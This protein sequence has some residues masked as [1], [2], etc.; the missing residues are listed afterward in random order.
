MR[1]H[2]IIFSILF[3]ITSCKKEENPG[4]TAETN[5][6]IDLQVNAQGSLYSLVIL[7]DYVRTQPYTDG[8]KDC[9]VRNTD[10]SGI[11]V[12][13][14]V[15]FSSHGACFATDPNHTSGTFIA[16]YTTVETDTVFIDLNGIVSNGFQYSGIL[17]YVTNTSTS[18][19]TY[20]IVGNNISVSLEGVVSTINLNFNLA[21]SGG[22][23]YM[24]S[25]T[26]SATGSTNFTWMVIEQLSG[27]AIENAY[28]S[29]YNLSFYK[30]KAQLLIGTENFKMLYGEVQDNLI[31]VEDIDRKR[32][33]IYQA[34]I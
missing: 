24:N 11:N 14:S 3:S 7:H 23:M 2:I 32:Q 30:G 25:G 26:M 13:D 8:I 15:K 33:G 12:T 10:T 1:Y 31:I 22:L 27:N 16:N 6:V 17:K 9:F 4:F 20:T 21:E 18:L 28:N 5:A 34:K 19:R 29:L